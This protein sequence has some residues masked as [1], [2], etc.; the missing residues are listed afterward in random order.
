MISRIRLCAILLATMLY[1]FEAATAVDRGLAFGGTGGVA[2]PFGD[3]RDNASATF[4]PSEEGLSGSLNA[5]FAVH[6]KIA[7]TAG[8]N[9]SKFAGHELEKKRV[10]F[11]EA[12][13]QF[14]NGNPERLWIPFFGMAVGMGKITTKFEDTQFGEALV[15]LTAD[16]DWHPGAKVC[17]GARRRLSRHVDFRF[18][19]EFRMIHIDGEDV[20]I[21]ETTKL[22]SDTHVERT[23]DLMVGDVTM[24]NVGLG[25][26]FVP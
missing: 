26:L 23:T 24:F 14:S 13:L 17:L 3:I 15:N 25:L 10:T 1:P 8:Y 16:S 6:R 12:G 2:F 7:L 19:A 18:A 5:E 20:T 9:Y 22:G 4:S 11:L 21:V